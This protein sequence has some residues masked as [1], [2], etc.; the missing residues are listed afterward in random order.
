[1][2]YEVSLSDDTFLTV[3]ADDLKTDR[4]GVYLV[5]RGDT[6]YS[7]QVVSYFPHGRVLYV[8]GEPE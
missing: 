3:V 5:N 6:T 2:K 7:Y 8:N 4:D 1:M